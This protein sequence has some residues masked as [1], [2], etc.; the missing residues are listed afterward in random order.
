MYLEK[1]QIKSFGKITGLSLKLEKGLNIIYGDN[2]SGKTTLQ[3]FIR[4]MLYGLRGGRAA[5]DGQLPPLKRYKPWTPG[6]YGGTLEY[7]LD[8]GSSY[9]VDR[10]FDRN[11]VSVYD[12]FFN[13]ISGSFDSSR[14]RGLLFADKHLGL[15]DICFEKTVLI[16]QMEARLDDSGAGELQSRLVNITQTGFD[17]LSFIKAEAALKSAIKK[18]VGTDR[19][20]TQPLDRIAARL[21]G[22]DR[23]RNELTEKRN[24]TAEANYRLQEL[25][26]AQTVLKNR[27]TY[28]AGLKEPVA[29]RTQLEDIKNRL[30]GLE[31]A[32][33]RLGSVSGE[34]AQALD[35]QKKLQ[36][37]H[38]SKEGRKDSEATRHNS[39]KK[40][41]LLTI[42]SFAA[43][44]VFLAAGVIF[45]PYWFI[46]A[47]LLLAA[48]TAALLRPGRY[49]GDNDSQSRPDENR[50]YGH[51]YGLVMQQVMEL[52]GK[53]KDILSEASLIYGKQMDSPVSLDE[54]VLQAA[55]LQQELALSLERD[56][57][58][59]V[60][61]GIGV[62]SDFFTP[63]TLKSTFYDSNPGWLRDSWEYEMEKTN[64]GLVETALKIKEY[65]TLLRGFDEE[66]EE[67][68]GI[69]EEAAVLELKRQELEGTGAALRLALEALTEAS[70]EIRRN[71]APALN[72]KM[73]GI[74]AGITSGKYSELKADDTLALKAVSP[75][76]GDV[77][78][79]LA[80]SGGTVDQMYL[81]L[82]LAMSDLLSHGG[83]SLP[84]LLDEVFSQYDDK[85][86]EHTLEYLINEYAGRQILLFTCKERELETAAAVCGDKLNVIRL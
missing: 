13:D 2:E 61:A 79:V 27:K 23:K 73:S 57:N 40:N 59:A 14:D 45:K 32:A 84:L 76:S 62:E 4:G 19:T 38:E 36:K 60:Q 12:A 28:L 70:F 86:A 5:K 52:N 31:A 72:D 46:T 25:M 71:Y 77:R 67:L 20:T 47:A 53:L 48:G 17:D 9:R 3:W 51:A 18:Y 43:A 33:G 83:E 39:P 30:A 85:R 34:L 68:Q 15:D 56:L 16:R 78:S 24:K 55:Q 69:E 8:N 63:G 74:I 1:L 66:G 6:S 65:E 41:I 81:A 82:R 58:R 37:N 49:T 54:A 10:D 22:L 11:T 80:L 42:L 7:R 26:E 29:V 35:E 44:A 75:D 21:A 50:E 64:D